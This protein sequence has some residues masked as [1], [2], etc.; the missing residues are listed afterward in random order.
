MPLKLGVA[1]V[2]P[3][4]QPGV[5]QAITL[6]V[7]KK[8]RM[9]GFL[10]VSVF[11]ANPLETTRADVLSV[12]RT[13]DAAGLEVSQ[14]NGWYECLVNPDDTLRHAGVRGVETLIRLGREMNAQSIYVRPGS[15]NPRGHWWPHPE[16]H[17]AATFDR[18]VDSL[19]NACGTAATEGMR[20]AV[21]G[22]VLS[23]L[24]SPRTVRKLLDLV[25]SPW[26]K[27]NLDPVNFIGTVM[28][29]HDT[30]PI[31]VQLFNLLG[32]DSIIAHAKDCSL[33]DALVL[34]I[35]EVIPGQGTMDYD[36]FL[37]RFAEYQPDGTILVEHLPFEKISTARDAI[38]RAAERSAI[39]LRS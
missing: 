23:P 32:K 11:I 22:H 2:L 21:E 15:I 36:L 27:F 29:V 25:D 35:N 14:V 5:P 10:G 6:E 19:R 28:D 18:L 20:L 30:K 26:L 33:G 31:L 39:E 1:Q 34:H 24:D 13:L 12:K 7:A 17:S 3:E 4:L 9:L 16:N 37:R 38:L 8:I